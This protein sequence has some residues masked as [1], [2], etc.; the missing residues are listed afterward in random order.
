MRLLLLLF[1]LNFL[2]SHAQQTYTVKDATQLTWQGKAAFGSYAPEG[3]LD[4][5]GGRINLEN[6]SI[7]QLNV[8]IDM[9]TLSQENKQL[10]GHLRNADFFD[11]E[12]FDKASFTMTNKLSV[13]D[14]QATLKGV[15][16]IKGQS[17]AEE[18]PVTIQKTATGVIITFNHT[19]DRTQYGINYNSPSFFKR[20]KENAID[21]DFTLKGTLEFVAA[22]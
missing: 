14:T 6:D 7:T 21:D 5:S 20:L 11:V 4:I 3:T 8:V 9:T 1:A 16:T 15:M 18:I 17:R 10:E 12:L 19:M 22:N 13:S 2:T